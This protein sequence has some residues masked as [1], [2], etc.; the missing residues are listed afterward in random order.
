AVMALAQSYGTVIVARAYAEWNHLT[1]R[2]TTYKAGIEP[3]FA[4]VLRTDS[5][6]GNGGGKSLAD[7]VIVADGVDLLWRM[8]PDVMVLATSDKD[9]IPLVRLAKQRGSQ[10]V[11][12][13]SDLT[14]VQLVELANYFVTYRQL[15][16]DFQPE[17][18]RERLQ[19]REL[20]R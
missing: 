14:A 9:L 18:E 2:L 7:T 12:V 4:P 8:S 3:A 13:G 16:G 17:R 5:R 6:G 10:V 19:E 11:V 20:P 15:V 1:E